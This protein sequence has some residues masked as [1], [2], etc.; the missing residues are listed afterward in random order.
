MDG[1]YH[2]STDA[3]VSTLTYTTTTICALVSPHL[4][5]P[6]GKYLGFR[7]MAHAHVCPA[8]SMGLARGADVAVTWHPKAGHHSV[9]SEILDTLRVFH[10]Y[11][12]KIRNHSEFME[13]VAAT[14]RLVKQ[15]TEFDW[16]SN[17]A[18][19]LDAMLIIW[20]PSDVA[21]VFAR[22]WFD[23][24]ARYSEREQLSFNYVASKVE[25]RLR[26]GYFTCA[27]CAQVK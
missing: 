7:A 25:G 15:D 19:I 8:A 22:A 23:H 11:P 5:S 18:L 10:R 6:T 17:R 9:R 1:T 4:L 16:T 26:V 2:G 27:I 3:R 20:N 12:G 24:V 14:Q 21:R 13:G